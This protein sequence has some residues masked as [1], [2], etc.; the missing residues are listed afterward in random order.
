MAASMCIYL[1]FVS[2]FDLATGGRAMIGAR[3]AASIVKPREALA[4]DDPRQK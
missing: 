2:V 4:F 3:G 1:V